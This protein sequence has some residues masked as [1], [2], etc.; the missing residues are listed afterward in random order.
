[1]P[2]GIHLAN[3]QERTIFTAQYTSGMHVIFSNADVLLIRSAGHVRISDARGVEE[4]LPASAAFC[5]GPQGCICPAG[6]VYKGPELTPLA[7]GAD[8][9]STGGPVG[10]LVRLSGLSL[11]GYCASDAQHPAKPIGT[12]LPD[13]CQLVTPDD[14]QPIMGQWGPFVHSGGDA[15]GFRHCTY[16]AGSTVV[17]G[18][19]L[20][21]V[22]T[23]IKLDSLTTWTFMPLPHI[24]DEAHFAQRRKA[25]PTGAYD[26]AAFLAI[27]RGTVWIVL[28]VDFRYSPCASGD[29]CIPEPPPPD[30]VALA[31]GRT[32]LS[33]L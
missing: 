18:I 23:R 15:A 10:A 2:H 5:T 29:A 20:V 30:S 4:V 11:A 33:R 7:E 8:L 13:P 9:A 14:V 16:E 21:G 25:Y 26:D 31:L 3:D 17:T 24:G 19:I 27:R 6:S 32:A 28:S 12:T 1:M 22:S